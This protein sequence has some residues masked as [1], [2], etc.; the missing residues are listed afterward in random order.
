MTVH[1]LYPPEEVSRILSVSLGTLAN[2]RAKRTGPP[3]INLNGGAGAVRYCDDQLA[4]W[5]AAEFDK[6]HPVKEKVR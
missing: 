5:Q 1:T 2:W 3:Y 6:Q 4:K